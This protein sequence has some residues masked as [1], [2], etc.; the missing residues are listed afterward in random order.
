MGRE[1]RH[2]PR[3]GLGGIRGVQRRQD[4]VTRLGRRQPNLDGLQIAHLAHQDDVGILAQ[5]SPQ[6]RGEREAV[7]TN[8]ALGDD[9]ALVPHQELHRVLHG[10]DVAVA[11]LVDVVD[12]RSERGRLSRT[13]CAGHENEPAVVFG[14][15]LHHGRQQQRID[16]LDL[17]RDDPQH[18]ADGAPLHE[19]VDPK[20]ADAAH[21]VAEV[22]VEPLPEHLLQMA[23][24]DI[25]QRAVEFVDR[26]PLCILEGKQRAVDAEHRRQSDS[27][28]D[29]ASPP[30][31]RHCQHAVQVHRPPRCPAPLPRP[32]TAEALATIAQFPSR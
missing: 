19:G 15:C 16:G 4:E 7:C 27:E 20:A 21:A 1:G 2:Q 6:R 24:H 10:N 11:V 9:G 32:T 23:R 28:V 13:G 8:L 26:E 3:D 18:H 12:D 5:R 30:F 22:A 29:I 17:E 14:D 25:S 31:D